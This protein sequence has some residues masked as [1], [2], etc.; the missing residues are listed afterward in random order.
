MVITTQGYGSAVLPSNAGGAAA[1]ATPLP[2]AAAATPTTTAATPATAQPHPARNTA[3]QIQTMVSNAARPP[4]GVPLHLQR[5]PTECMMQWM[6]TLDDD[7]RAAN[8]LAGRT[9]VQQAGMNTLT[10]LL[11]AAKEK[12]LRHELS[13]ADSRAYFSQV[14]ASC[15][16][17]GLHRL[18]DLAKHLHSQLPGVEHDN[19]NRDRAE[20]PHKTRLH[21]NVYGRRYDSAFTAALVANPPQR[22]KDGM[23]VVGNAIAHRYL[24]PWLTPADRQIHGAT[25]ARHVA[26]LHQALNDDPRSWG[27]K[28]P[29]LQSF[30]GATDPAAKHHA[31]DAF[32]RSAKD[33]GIDCL[34]IPYVAVKLLIKDPWPTPAW[35]QKADQNYMGVIGGQVNRQDK[36]GDFL[37]ALA[38][39][40]HTDYATLQA[41][42]GQATATALDAHRNDPPAMRAQRQQAALLRPQ[43]E[44]AVRAQHEAPCRAHTQSTRPGRPQAAVE[45]EVQAWLAG[46]VDR[47]V[48]WQM[49]AP[50]RTRLEA[51]LRTE[52]Q[53]ELRLQLPARLDAQLAAH[54]EGLRKAQAAPTPAATLRPPLEAKLVER[55][56]S[57]L[58]A[59]AGTPH[60]AQT[61]APMNRAQLQD[62]LATQIAEAAAG[63]LLGMQPPGVL[64][65]CAHCPA[66]ARSV[67]DHGQLEIAR[68]LNAWSFAHAE[69]RTRETVETHAEIGTMMRHQG[70]M[71][72]P[73]QAGNDPLQAAILPG[74]RNRIDFDQVEGQRDH[75]GNVIPGP[76]DQRLPAAVQQALSH[77][78]PWVGG[79]SG[80]TNLMLHLSAD[81]HGTPGDNGA[82][83]LFE[84]KDVLLATMMFVNYDGGHSLHSS[85]WVG[86]QLDA[87]PL[88]AQP[89]PAEPQQGPGLGLGLDLDPARGPALAASVAAAPSRDAALALAARS[90]EEFVS[91]YSQLM[92]GQAGDEVRQA[93]EQAFTETMQHFRERSRYASRPAP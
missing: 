72:A 43:T 48:Q 26:D 61:L 7:I 35:R 20:L 84:Q 78:L 19:F 76:L 49:A 14:A 81:L 30:L 73:P 15:E 68:T 4:L 27:L 89:P 93:A 47:Q 37:N 54:V 10:A 34:A 80:T 11:P 91:D 41:R 18:R 12:W 21:D 24:M 59:A 71:P 22:M 60:T 45:A 87:A 55:L 52:L 17:A 50:M 2:P 67:L 33:N 39:A 44:T 62:L 29:L 42:L 1:P 5:M 83:Q 82:P 36:Q 56:R 86:N 66:L 51:T 88:A 57:Q 70:A 92:V 25:I 46:E 75:L 40:Q 74:R 6:A 31:L 69:V 90:A 53:A 32:L 9:P 16:Q 79:V 8:A 65:S 63:P 28:S 77:G 13:F 64:A 38:R 3:G 58:L 23:A 85:M